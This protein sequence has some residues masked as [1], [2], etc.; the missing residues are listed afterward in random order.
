MSRIIG[1]C[2]PSGSGKTALANML[3]TELHGEVIGLDN[4]FLLDTPHKKYNDQGKDL[5]LPENT[6]WDAV[7]RTLESIR[8]NKETTVR[9]ISWSTNSY[10]EHVIQP[11]A[12]TIV[13]GFHLF[14]DETVL[15]NLDYKVYID[16]SDET[17]TERRVLR[18]GT[19]TNRKWFEEVTFPE[20]RKWS[21][22]Y[23]SRADIVLDGEKPLE[24]VFTTL[25]KSLDQ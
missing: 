20:Y 7:K 2:G 16:I 19:D 15:K 4:Y 1:L 5:E 13:E 18:E 22:V 25:V 21:G 14:Y 6:N 24:T 12:F 17:G 11:T 8:K 23:R 9:D 10:S 3:A